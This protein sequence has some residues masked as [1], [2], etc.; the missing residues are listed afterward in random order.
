MTELQKVEFNILREFVA[1]CEKLNLR[2]YLVCGSALG[3]V[4]YRGFIPWDDD[5]DVALPRADYE[6]FIR[7]AHK[8]LPE[9][10]FVQN[11]HS[12]KQLHFLGTKLRDSRTTYVEKMC[13]K[14]DI[15]HGVFIDVFALDEQYCDECNKNKMRRLRKR[16]DNVRIVRLTYRRFLS[17][18]VF[19]FRN[20]YY[21]LF[22]LFGCF[23]DTSKY[24][25]RFDRFAAAA[26]GCGSGHLCNHAN[27]NSESEFAP[28]WHYGDGIEAEF[29]GLKVRIPENYDEYLTQKYGNWRADLPKDEQIGHHYYYK[30]DLDR[31][32]TY[33]Y[34]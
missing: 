30:C 21:I 13:E 19:K 29:E 22:K 25:A 3:A 15:H 2:Y 9:W 1:V 12:E 6:I 27:S 5:I 16:T 17:R 28:D 10:C 31:P 20:I 23:S 7:N 14:M 33:Y 26:N 8:L 4:K 32:Y 11:Y 18:E 34:K 24:V